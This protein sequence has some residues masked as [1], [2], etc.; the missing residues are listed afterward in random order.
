MCSLPFLN[1]WH[2]YPI[3]TFYEE[4]LAFLLGVAAF[5][6]LLFG[7]SS[8]EALRVP[9]TSLWLCAFAAVLAL[10]IPLRDFPYPQVVLIGATYVLW[11]ALVVVAGDMLRDR[12]GLEPTVRTLAWFVLFA[13]LVNSLLA[14][15]Q[16]FHLDGPIALLLATTVT[17]RAT[18]NLAQPNLLAD[19]LALG[20]GCA[21]YL[22]ATGKLRTIW[23]A[24]ALMLL[25]AGMSLTV[26]RAGSLLIAWIVVWAWWA[27]RGMETE[28]SRR[29]L[30]AA[31]F[32]AGVFFVFQ[33]LIF[34]FGLPDTQQTSETTLLG[35]SYER[36]ES[37]DVGGSV[38]S[39]RL[40]LWQQA[41]KVFLAHP[42]LGIGWGQLPWG[43]FSQ[44]D[45]SVGQEK[46]VHEAY[47]H[48]LLLQLL[49]ETGIAGTIPIAAGLGSWLW[50]QSRASVTP[51]RWWILALAGVEL[52]H[53]MIEFPLWYSSFLGVLALLVGLGER[54]WIAP[55]LQR[56]IPAS[57]IAVVAVSA[58]ILVR[59]WQDYSK[60]WVWLYISLGVRQEQA[61]SVRPYT[62]EVLDQLGRS[63]LVAYM[64]MPASG[65]IGMNRDHL[66]EKIAFHERVMR[67]NPTPEIVYRHVLLLAMA[68]RDAEAAALLERAMRLYPERIEEFLKSAA[69]LTEP[70]AGVVPE[71][72]RLARARLAQIRSANLRGGGP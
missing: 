63:L 30:R 1:P 41:W 48:N 8:G 34:Q 7:R 6:A 2:Y 32:A 60:L 57:A 51:E 56:V 40:F 46:V 26:S 3:A 38:Y 61:E 13:A 33:V 50:R 27:R 12:V 70:E 52:I 24:A 39:I 49:A 4:W 35:R 72:V 54:S 16:F 68:G 67:F 36:L 62:K 23:F 47:A 45:F 28:T 65:M 15:V 18:A 31:L 58:V 42:I 5:L 17:T 55:R 25:L 53:S 19:L 64:D 9:L 69:T 29:L 20:L 10:Q 71:V 43:M 14:I 21:V 59:T 37:F 44:L 11:A 22:R 66:Q